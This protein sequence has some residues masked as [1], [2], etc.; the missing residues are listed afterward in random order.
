ML[1]LAGSLLLPETPNSLMQ[2]GR[3]REAYRVIHMNHNDDTDQSS[4]PNYL[5]M[6]PH[7]AG[8]VLEGC[9]SLDVMQPTNTTEDL[10]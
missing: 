3:E 10:A 5:A 6:Q 9:R 4:E 7:T 2:R 1:V 8:T